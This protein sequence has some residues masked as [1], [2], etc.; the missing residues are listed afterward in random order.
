MLK[1]LTVWIT[2]NCGKFSDGNTDHRTRL[3]RNLYA[4]QEAAVRIRHETTDWF[5]TE[6]G[7]YRGCTLSPCLFNVCAE[8]IMWNAGLNDSQ[9]LIKIVGRN[10][11]NLRYA[12]NTKPAVMVW[13]WELDCKEGWALKNWCFGTRLPCHSN[14]K[15]SAC[16]AGGQGS[17]PGLESSSGEGNGNPL[18]C[19]CLKN[20]MNR[21]AWWAIVHWIAKSWTQLRD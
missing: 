20:S 14:S 16:K 4:G 3:L 2:T 6:W 21:E 15:E 8:Y 12:N 13:M 7:A 18:Q 17:I 19:S 5:K 1:P 11:N 9:A 10:I